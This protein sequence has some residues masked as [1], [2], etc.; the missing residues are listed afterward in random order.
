MIFQVGPWVICEITDGYYGAVFVWGVYLNGMFL[1]G[2]LTYIYG[3]AQLLLCKLPLIWFYTKCVSKRYYQAIG[4][5]T[6]NHR[7][8]WCSTRKISK[9][10]F[11]SIIAIE[12][13]LSIFFGILYGAVAFFLGFFRTWS[14]ILNIYLWYLARNVPD[15]A[16]R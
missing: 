11:F 3:F 8:W 7:G 16:L 1:P 6:K 12:I 13:L 4:M 9:A 15:H 14:V 10:V 5:P 2:S